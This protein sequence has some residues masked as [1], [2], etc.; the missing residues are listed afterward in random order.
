M[1]PKTSEAADMHRRDRGDPIVV[2]E[3]LSPST[4]RRD[5]RWKRS[6][7]TGLASLTHYVIVA[8]DA[9]DVLVF[10]RDTGFTEHRIRDL[11]S[12]IELP[13]LG[14]ALPMADIYRDTGLAP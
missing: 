2:F 13:S 7:Y 4:Q 3:I 10:S 12:A 9:V 1:I 14:V 11:G 8:Q 5:L 6:A